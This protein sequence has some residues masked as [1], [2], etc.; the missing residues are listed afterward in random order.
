MHSGFRV[1]WDSHVRGFQISFVRVFWVVSPKESDMNFPRAFAA[2]SCVFVFVGIDATAIAQE[3]IV[4]GWGDNAY[5]QSIAPTDLGLCTQIAAGSYHTAVIQLVGNVKAWGYNSHGQTDVPTGLGA[6][7]QIAAGERYTV[8][9][10]E[11]GIVR[12]WGYNSDGQCNIPSDL[13]VCTQ[14][15]S[16]LNHTIALTQKGV[17]RTW[18]NN[19]AVDLP[20]FGGH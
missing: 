5:G 2:I 3:G 7:T 9:L 16:G 14:I 1:I 13:G 12:A 18:G 4:V 20:R 6:C 8:A 11:D 17:V 19:W 10:R 15:A